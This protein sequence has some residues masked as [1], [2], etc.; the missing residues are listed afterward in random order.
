MKEQEGQAP[1]ALGKIKSFDN[2]MEDLT[3]FKETHGHANVSNPE[4]KSLAAFCATTRSR[5]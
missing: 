3:R 2:L 4:D 5:T 1:K